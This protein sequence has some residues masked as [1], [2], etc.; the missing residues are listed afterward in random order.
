[1]E[2]S[3]VKTKESV[4]EGLVLTLTLFF[5]VIP[6]LALA[7]PLWPE[8]TVSVELGEESNVQESL[9]L[10]SKPYSTR[11]IVTLINDSA[12]ES[13]NIW[14]MY[15]DSHNDVAVYSRYVNVPLRNA[16]QVIFGAS[17]DVDIVPR[18]IGIFND[19]GSNSTTVINPRNATLILKLQPQLFELYAYSNLVSR[20]ETSIEIEGENQEGIEITSFWLQ[21]VFDSPVYPVTIDIQRTNGV[22]LYSNPM[23]RNVRSSNIPYSSGIPKLEFRFNN[24]V[25]LGFFAPTQI[26]DTVMLPSGNYTVNFVWTGYNINSSIYLSE[27]MHQMVWRVRSVRIDVRATHYVSNYGVDFNYASGLYTY[28]ISEQPSIYTSPYGNR[29]IL[30]RYYSL[31]WQRGVFATA[32]VGSNQNVTFLVHP[33]LIYIGPIAIAP[34]EF[35]TI[36]CFVLM[37][38]MLIVASM[39]G[40]AKSNKVIPFLILILSYIVP[41]ANMLGKEI[42]PSTILQEEYLAQYAFFP[43]TSTVSIT[44]SNGMPFAVHEYRV[45]PVMLL[46]LILLFMAYSAVAGDQLSR[47]HKSSAQIFAVSS[48]SI[49]LLHIY[50]ISSL[51]IS[52]SYYVVTPGVGIFIVIASIIIWGFLDIRVITR[53]K[54][55][56]SLSNKHSIES[57]QRFD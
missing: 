50:Y 34:A 12:I 2:E 53:M 4:S 42:D 43:G 5:I 8:P 40:E 35:I 17:F 11:S 1:M 14:R 32:G 20:I 3:F 41:W 45:A 7:T 6:I 18:R 21:A 25:Y 28:L 47:F 30:I 54:S 31:Y 15:F 33:N 16:T 46:G 22:S 10:T 49:I 48:V 44:T 55:T 29:T 38:C 23:M 51:T 52:H 56:E 26:N 57:E 24:S 19:R 36:L 13:G 9:T 39:L 37:I 27:E